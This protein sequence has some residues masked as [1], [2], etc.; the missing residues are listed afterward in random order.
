MSNGNGFS[1]PAK[2]S[3]A[4]VT[5][6]GFTTTIIGIVVATLGSMAWMLNIHAVNPHKEAVTKTE[7]TFVI[8]RLDRIENKVDKLK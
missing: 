2:A 3:E 5:W 8:D 4:C 7:I 1:R 6:K